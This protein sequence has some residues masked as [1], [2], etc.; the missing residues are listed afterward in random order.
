M[1][2]FDWSIQ[3]SS[4][5][6]TTILY[7]PNSSSLSHELRMCPKG[8][9]S[10]HLCL[11]L[12]SCFSELFF[13]MSFI[14]HHYS[15]QKVSTGLLW[16]VEY[17]QHNGRRIHQVETSLCLWQ[18]IVWSAGNYD[19]FTNHL[20]VLSVVKNTYNNFDRCAGKSADQIFLDGDLH[21]L[22]L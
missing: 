17:H 8:E 21:P 22:Q 4:S 7:I 20:D 9:A 15:I 16:T 5:S 2:N 6:C 12:W 1:E 13:L 19:S 11:G 14:Y 18:M 3:V 10:P